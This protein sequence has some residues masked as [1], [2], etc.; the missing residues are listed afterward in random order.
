MSP[1]AR[2]KHPH[3]STVGL[4]LPSPGRQRPPAVARAPAAASETDLDLALETDLDLALETET[5][6]PHRPRSTRL[7]VNSHFRAGSYGRLHFETS[8]NQQ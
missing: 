1:G 8:P 5:N 7:E 6:P 2:K 3:E 4:P